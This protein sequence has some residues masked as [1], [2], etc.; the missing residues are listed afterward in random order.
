MLK[1]NHINNLPLEPEDQRGGRFPHDFYTLNF[2]T[3][4]LQV[5]PAGISDNIFRMMPPGSRS[6]IKVDIPAEHPSG[7][8]WYHP[9]VH[10]AATYQFVSGMAGFL[11][12]KGGPGTLDEVPEV[13]AA[14]DLVMGF[15][16][17]RADPKG[18]VP[19]VNEQATQFGT[20]PFGHRRPDLARRVEHLRLRWRSGAEQFLL[21]HQRR[22]Q[23]HR[24][25]A[26]R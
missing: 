6:P 25:H 22:H 2:H 10:G 15:Q 24:P 23:P 20:F 14:K 18:K 11:I 16:V 13:K 1:I 8:F 3:H 4:G 21:H 17:I 9:H 19:G 12:I 26:S 5:S 7:T